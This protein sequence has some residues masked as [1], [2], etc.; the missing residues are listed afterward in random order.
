MSYAERAAHEDCGAGATRR[1]V[2]SSSRS[3]APRPRRSWSARCPPARHG[4][5]ATSSRTSPAS[6]RTSTAA[7]SV[8][9]IPTRGPRGRSIGSAPGRSSDV[10]AAWDHEAPTFEDGLRLFGY[11]VGNHFVGDLLHPPDRRAGR[12]RPPGRPRRHRDV[13]RARLVP[14][15]ARRRT[16]PTRTSARSRSRPA[17]E[18]RVVGPGDVAA[19]RHRRAVRDAARLRGP[20]HHRRDRGLPMVRATSTRSS[21]GSAAT[22]RPPRRRRRRLDARHPGA[23]LRRSARGST[24]RRGGPDRP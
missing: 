19:E 18:T 2:R 24:T 15:L 7:I 5:S 23:R 21:A 11:Q 9:G 10:V 6:P 14:R 20:P 12:A 22:R 16:S 17:P 1:C 4:A 3:S 13:D 8:P